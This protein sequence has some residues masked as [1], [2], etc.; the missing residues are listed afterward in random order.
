MS[1]F[2]DVGLRAGFMLFLFLYQLYTYL[3][4]WNPSITHCESTSR[5]PHNKKYQSF[6]Q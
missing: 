5:H 6:L 3:P 4:V 2:P 1:L